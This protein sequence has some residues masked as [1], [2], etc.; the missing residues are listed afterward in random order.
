MVARAAATRVAA[1][2][3]ARVHLDRVAIVALLPRVHAPIAADLAS[4]LSITAITNFHI[5]VVAS[6]NAK[7]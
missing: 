4:A 6:F 2:A 1:T 3:G 7:P 5:P